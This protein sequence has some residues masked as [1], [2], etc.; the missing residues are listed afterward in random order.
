[1]LAVRRDVFASSLGLANLLGLGIPFSLQAFGI[2]LDLLALGL[3]FLE[4]GNI[5]FEAASGESGC[6][7][8]E[9]LAEQL[10][11]KHAT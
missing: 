1:M 10:W 2:G 9:I 11:I 3:E 7:I 8:G 4:S 5:K 6:R